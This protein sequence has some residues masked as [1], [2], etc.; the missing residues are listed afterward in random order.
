MENFAT[1]AMKDSMILFREGREGEGRY[2]QGEG[3]GI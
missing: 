1:Y 3:G 2:L